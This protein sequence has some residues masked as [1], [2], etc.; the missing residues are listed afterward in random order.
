MLKFQM[1]GME[2]KQISKLRDSLFG[3]MSVKKHELFKD[4]TFT[5][6]RL[7]DACVKSFVKNILRGVG[8]DK[9]LFNYYSY[10]VELQA[11]GIPNIHGVA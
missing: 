7:Y 2:M 11:R 9:I 5:I 3:F 1:V 8:K 4:Y 10:R 6:T